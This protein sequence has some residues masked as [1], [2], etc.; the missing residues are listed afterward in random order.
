MGEQRRFDRFVLD[1]DAGALLADGREVRL[2]PLVYRLLVRLTDTPG[3]LVSRDELVR[4]LWPDVHVTEDSLSQVIRRLRTA[5]GSADLVQS[6]PRRGY[7]F[8]APV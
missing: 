5:F 8:T 6:L 1:T 3:A 2:Q 4:T 7:R